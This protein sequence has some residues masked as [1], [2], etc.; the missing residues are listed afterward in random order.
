M[1]R[2]NQSQTSVTLLKPLSPPTPNTHLPS[3]FNTGVPSDVHTHSNL[4][5]C[6]DFEKV[7]SSHSPL[8]LNQPDLHS[9]EQQ[10]Q[11]EEEEGEGGEEECACER[12]RAQPS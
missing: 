11:E 8:I 5:R 2:K 6:S 4:I 3:L 7:N 10:Q 1:F 9:R 12:L